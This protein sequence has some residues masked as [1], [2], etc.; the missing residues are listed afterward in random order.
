METK[1]NTQQIT[2]RNI[3]VTK[4]QVLGPTKQVA[5]HVLINFTNTIIGY[6][7]SLVT[8]R[9]KRLQQTRKE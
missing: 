5:S 1:K 8:L 4:E 6:A 3:N 9:E 2:E 7:I